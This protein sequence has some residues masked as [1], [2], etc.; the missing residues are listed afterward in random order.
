M[1]DGEA[2]IGPTPKSPQS[3]NSWALRYLGWI[4]ALGALST[5]AAALIGVFV[6][7]TW[8][9]LIGQTILRSGDVG[10]IERARSNIRT[11]GISIAT[12][13]A[14]A[15]A[16]VLAWG[17]LELSRADHLHR[18]DELAST[19]ARA[20]QER[21]QRESLA[22]DDRSER[23]RLELN[24]RFVRSVEL[25]GSADEAVRLGALYS[26]EALAQD[27]ADRSHRQSVV[28]VI[29]AFLRYR[30]TALP[31]YGTD[32]FDPSSVPLPTDYQAAAAIALR[33]PADWGVTLTL[34]STILRGHR[35]PEALGGGSFVRATLVKCQFVGS[36]LTDCRFDG[37]ALTDCQFEKTKF[38]NCGLERAALSKCGFF[39]ASWTNCVAAGA[40]L[41]ECEFEEATLTGC[42]FGEANL[43]RC[44]FDD[45]KMTYCS[46]EAARL[47]DCTLQGATLTECGFGGK[48]GLEVSRATLANCWFHHAAMSD[49]WFG[50]ATLTSCQF[51]GATLTQCSFYAAGLTDCWFCA[52][53]RLETRDAK[54]TGC[55]FDEVTL[56][57]CVWP[58]DYVPSSV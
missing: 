30:T 10:A 2:Q 16:G 34:D 33:S 23:D 25:L 17:R 8:D 54:M 4:V 1:D 3:T 6:L 51:T 21:E 56:T 44:S 13:C 31:A 20:A 50:E 48:P 15:T 5:I 24:S 7:P 32:A 42:W 12:G 45:A 40:T 47:T 35:V 58:H 18:L 37:A 9:R 43:S 19:E 55:T 41:S 26:L 52:D 14:A 28:D 38:E 49:C 29:C 22:R 46:F 57:G 11:V 36:T 39:G 27:D 53:K